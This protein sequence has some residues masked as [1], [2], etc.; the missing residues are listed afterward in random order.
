MFSSHHVFILLSKA[1]AR[2]YIFS[3]D[4]E[5]SERR[6]DLLLTK[7]CFPRLFF[8][9]II[10]VRHG[11]RALQDAL[12]F[13]HNVVPLFPGISHSQ[14]TL[15]SD[16]QR[17]VFWTGTRAT[18]SVAFNVSAMLRG[19]HLPRM[20]RRLHD[21]RLC[22]YLLIGAPGVQSSDQ[23]LSSGPSDQKELTPQVA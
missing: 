1:S 19:S 9:A 22:T 2:P 10:S 18:I 7:V 15:T 23:L 16:H 5:Y 13:S 21:L 3:T 17:R 8:Y 6:H 12:V 14:S 20:L 11:S 4:F